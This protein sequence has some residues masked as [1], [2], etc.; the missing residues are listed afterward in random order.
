MRSNKRP[1]DKPQPTSGDALNRGPA[2]RTMTLIEILTGSVS[3]DSSWAV[4]AE[5]IDGEFRGDSPARF[6]Q[7]IFENGGLMDDC[8]FFASNESIV[9][10]IEGWTEGDEDADREEGAEMLISEVNG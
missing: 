8:E 6:G 5:K 9:D 4:Y 1:N 2:L 3:Y 7:Q 10:A